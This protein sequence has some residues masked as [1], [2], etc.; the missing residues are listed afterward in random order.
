[1]KYEFSRQSPNQSKASKTQRKGNDLAQG[2]ILFSVTAYV[3]FL[4]AF[5]PGN[6]EKSY[7]AVHSAFPGSGL[8]TCRRWYGFIY[9]YI[10]KRR[11]TKTYTAS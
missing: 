6:E 10:Y 11:F 8:F 4:S 5:D 7:I 2:H 1:M 3:L 9:I